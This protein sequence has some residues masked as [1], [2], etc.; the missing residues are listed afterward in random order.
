MDADFNKGEESGYERTKKAIEKAKENLLKD[1]SKLKLEEFILPNNEDDGISETL[2][3]K[4][5]KCQKIVNYITEKVIPDIE[6]N[7]S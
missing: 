7:V 6:N 5:M 2:I 3:L 4:S 1:N